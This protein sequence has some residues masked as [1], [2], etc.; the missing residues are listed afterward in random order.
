MPPSGEEKDS[1]Q[2]LYAPCLF[3]PTADG[4]DVAAPVVILQ[5]DG[6]NIYA[7]L[8]NHINPNYLSQPDKFWKVVRNISNPPLETWRPRVYG[9]QLKV[10]YFFVYASITFMSHHP[11]SSQ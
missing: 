10:S 4:E 7:V 6:A 2:L 1:I 8:E 11:I 5:N 9:V 3:L